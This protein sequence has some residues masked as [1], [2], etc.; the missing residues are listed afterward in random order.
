MNSFEEELT[1][2]LRDAA[3]LPSLRG[4]EEL[5][6]VEK[7]KTGDKEALNRLVSAYLQTIVNIAR[8]KVR[9]RCT[10]EE[11][12]PEG[13]IGLLR[14]IEG[15]NSFAQK[16]WSFASYVEQNASEAI[17]RHAMNNGG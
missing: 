12:V 6:L 2:R 13:N 14:A 15:F 7:A 16:T 1:T 9:G 5:A 10:L 8:T 4:E 3:A 11:L 17:S